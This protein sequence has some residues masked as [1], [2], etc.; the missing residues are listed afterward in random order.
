MGVDTVC[1]GESIVL[2][3]GGG[4]VVDAGSSLVLNNTLVVQNVSSSVNIGE[5]GVL[6][7]M[8]STITFE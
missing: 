5:E 2:G 4:V 3:S 1:S 8:D 6:D 7:L